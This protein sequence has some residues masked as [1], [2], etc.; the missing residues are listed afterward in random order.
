M[1]KKV[2]VAVL[3]FCLSGSLYGQLFSRNVS[4][5][6]TVAA[7]FLQIPVGAR[8]VAMGGAFVSVANDATALYWNAAGIVELERS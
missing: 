6:G 4:K 5:V 7:P 8:A 1:Q 2:F 3:C